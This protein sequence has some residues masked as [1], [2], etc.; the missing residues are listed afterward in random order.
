MKAHA[1]RVRQQGEQSLNKG[2][3]IRIRLE[4][5]PVY[6]VTGIKKIYKRGNIIFIDKE[7]R[8]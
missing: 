2:N 4:V 6:T 8:Q 1:T 3:P 7:I 5:I